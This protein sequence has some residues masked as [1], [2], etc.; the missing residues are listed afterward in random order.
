MRQPE[1]SS[2][3][4]PRP[5]GAF[6]TPGLS[7]LLD[8]LRAASAAT[9]VF[10]HAWQ[11]GLLGGPAWITPLQSHY[12]VIV[13]FVMSGLSIGTSAARPGMTGR[14]YALDRAMRILPVAAAAVALGSL[15]FV[16][17][18]G[19]GQVA[20]DS[21]DLA[22]TAGRI[23]YPLLF[24]T[25]S[26]RGV[27][28]LW[29]PAYWSLSYELWYYALFGAA[30][31]LKTRHR[32]LVLPGLA[33]VAGVPILLLMPVWLLGVALARWRALRGIGR[34]GGA[35]LVL[36]AGALAGALPRFDM[37]S[38]VWLQAHSPVA[39]VNT[40]NLIADSVLG[41]AVAAAL[42]G[43]RPW[44]KPLPPALAVLAPVLRWAAGMTFTVYLFHMP[45]LLTAESFGL[46]AI[47]APGQALAVM[48]GLFAACAVLA[49]LVERRTR[50]WRQ[51]LDR[52]AAA[53]RAPDM[54]PT[55]V[56]A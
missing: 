34:V 49:E 39:L 47:T 30:V 42:A 20:W 43:L 54:A 16:L 14:A 2:P 29:N 48:V 51:G 10:G 8:A 28:P 23:V 4:T 35:A 56:A 7:V 32:L 50:G 19:Q 13:F 18:H 3:D 45:L 33:L 46:R 36:L 5:G 9:V 38:L 6:I 22:L 53:G 31:F 41:L 44:L 11:C 40:Q 24:L 25:E 17:R 55:A 21:P 1:P 37:V 52:R 27:L 15:L 26:P 12:A